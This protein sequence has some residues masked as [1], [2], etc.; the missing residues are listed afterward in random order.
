MAENVPTNNYHLKVLHGLS[1][2]NLVWCKRS[3]C[4]NYALIEKCALIRERFMAP[5]TYL[6]L[7]VHDHDVLPQT[8]HGH[9]PPFE[10]TV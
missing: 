10:D 1:A 7:L 8:H 9:Y 6:G 2:N 5:P 3:L 4:N